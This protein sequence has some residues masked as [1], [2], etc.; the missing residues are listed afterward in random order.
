MEL[1]TFHQGKSVLHLLDTRVKLVAVSLFA[2]VVA[3][4]TGFETVLC[5]LCFSLVLLFFSQIKLKDVARRLLIVNGFT[6]FI[7]L[8]LPLTYPGAE[9]IN[10]S[11]LSISMDGVHLAL[12]ITLKT[13]TIVLASV[14][15]LG[16]SSVV[17]L[18]YGMQRLYIPKKLNLLLLFTYRYIIVIYQEFKRLNRAARLRCFSPGT[19]LHTYRTFGYLFGMTLVKS[20]QRAER[21]NDAMLL[22][23]FEG[24]FYSLNES[25]LRPSDL[26][27]GVGLL[28][29]P[30]L[31]AGVEVWY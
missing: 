19:N 11:F 25:V 22:R 26:I 29:V 20:W 30:V 4:S 27:L 28:L 16:T 23:G 9:T 5:G 12:L 13:N 2:L 1:E 6:L 17:D 10:V 18:G 21:V 14:S 7:W 3:V 31:L 15:L 8:T 24:K